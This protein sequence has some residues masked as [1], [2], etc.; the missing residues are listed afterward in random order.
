MKLTKSQ[1]KK[2]DT[3]IGKLEALQMSIKGST[4]GTGLQ[5]AKQALMQV[6]RSQ[7]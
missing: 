1:L 2:L 7:Q 6:Y 5:V 3:L 4:H